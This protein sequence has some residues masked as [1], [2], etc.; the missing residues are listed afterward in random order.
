VHHRAA[1]LAQQ[2]AGAAGTLPPRRGDHRNPRAHDVGKGVAIPHAKL[3]DL[4]GLYGVFARL[5]E[6]IDFDAVD[7][8]A[9]D[10]IFLLLAPEAAGADHL[11]AL[12]KISR[13]LRNGALCEKLRRAENANDVFPRGLT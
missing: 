12:A 7:D 9:V 1:A 2:K 6:P 13:V 11:K 4:D 10:L 3:A 8:Q 5:D